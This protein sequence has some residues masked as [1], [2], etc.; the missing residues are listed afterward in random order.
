MNTTFTAPIF[1]FFDVESSQR[2]IFSR[3]PLFEKEDDIIG[4][5]K[6]PGIR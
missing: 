1:I 2:M 6:I 3:L 5:K 4:K